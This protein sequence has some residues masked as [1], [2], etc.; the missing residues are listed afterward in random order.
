MYLW[1]AGSIRKDGGGMT[2]KH[3]EFIQQVEKDLIQ[4]IFDAIK[5]K[6]LNDGGGYGYDPL[7]EDDILIDGEDWLKIKKRFGIE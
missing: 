4:M 2:D 3:V 1:R 7:G 6:D 5:F